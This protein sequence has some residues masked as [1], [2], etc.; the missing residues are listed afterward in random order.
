MPPGGSTAADNDGHLAN[1]GIA[2]GDL[3]RCDGSG[4]LD[5][6]FPLNTQKLNAIFDYIGLPSIKEAITRL[7]GQGAYNGGQNDKQKVIG[8]YLAWSVAAKFK[9]LPPNG[10]SQDENELTYGALKNAGMSGNAGEVD[11]ILG[12]KG[13]N[14]FGIPSDLM[15]YLWGSNEH[16]CLHAILFGSECIRNSVHATSLNDQ[17]THDGDAHPDEPDG[18]RGGYN[19]KGHAPQ[20]GIWDQ[21]PNYLSTLGL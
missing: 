8:A 4:H 7:D 9:I 15:V 10:K 3:E 19:D 21:A 1:V 20:W 18:I 16:Q 13:A 11:K 6:G 14:K 2:P 17:D 12:E 5:M